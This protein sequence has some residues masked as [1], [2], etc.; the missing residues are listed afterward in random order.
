MIRVQ[1][2]LFPERM[3]NPDLD[4]RYDLPDLVAER[5]R[6]TVRD[7]G[8]RYGVADEG[9]APPL[10][11]SLLADDESAIEHVLDV[12]RNIPVLEND[13]KLATEVFVER[14]GR[15]ECIFPT[16]SA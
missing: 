9:K 3:S 4:I 1:V 12:V 7:G 2:K 6:R 5:S 13:L 8:Y 16:P 11:L 14:N 10:I 15:M